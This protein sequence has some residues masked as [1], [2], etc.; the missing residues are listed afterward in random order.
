MIQREVLVSFVLLSALSVV[1]ISC[2]SKGK[3][4]GSDD[5]AAANRVT[6]EDSRHNTLQRPWPGAYPEPI[7]LK[8]LRRVALRVYADRGIPS[9]R[10]SSG[11]FNEEIERRAVQELRKAGITLAKEDEA[12]AVLSLDVY[13]VCEADSSS[14][15]YQTDL[16]LKQWVQLHRDTSIAV[17]A[18]TWSNSYSNAIS[19]NQVY[20]CLPDLLSVDARSLLIGFV[21][22]LQK[23]N[24]Q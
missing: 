5:V 8:G 4:P 3:V 7:S 23:A 21:R 17:A 10:I 16:K 14:C 19:K 18:T 24:G 15:G 13:L 20:C 9:D 12:E 6:G 11:P 2:Q 22:D 1:T